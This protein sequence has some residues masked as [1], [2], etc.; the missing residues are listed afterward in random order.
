MEEKT[1]KK[2]TCGIVMPISSI[3]DC[4]SDHWTEVL[5]IVSDAA[6]SAGFEP[7]LVSDSEESGIIQKRIV[8]NIFHSDIVVAD[9]SAKN[10]NVMFELG[11][12]LAFDKPAIII[13]DNKTNYSF[14]TGVIEHLSYPR[15][16]HYYSIIEFKD[17]LQSK[18][19]ATYEASK[20][21]PAYTTFLKHF[22][23][24]TVA[25]IDNTEVGGGEF[26]LRAIEDLKEEVTVLRR[27]SK[28]RFARRE[29]V[30]NS[31]ELKEII[32]LHIKEYKRKK[33]I[34]FERLMSSTDKLFSYLEEHVILKKMAGSQ[35]ALRNAM[36]EALLSLL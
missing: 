6:K 17:V 29:P 1:L 26:I 21:D 30:S 7:S 9:V 24:Y 5:E 25:S 2:P 28:P 20:N 22:G 14:D 4:S 16:L 8:S 3:D 31:E 35:T 33:R 19:K 32:T 18:L 13:K 36:D 11:M 34:S 23:E 12:R 27:D 15:D 10:P